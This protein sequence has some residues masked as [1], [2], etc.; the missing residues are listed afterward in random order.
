MQ[1]LADFSRVVPPPLNSGWKTTLLTSVFFLLTSIFLL[2]H[3]TT[4]MTFATFAD[5]DAD[6]S[7]VGF[8]PPLN[9][10]W[11]TTL[12][13]SIF[14]PLTSVFLLPHGTTLMT[15][16]DVDADVGRF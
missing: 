1:M 3:G 9:T 2:P 15:F 7:R 10:G 14:F 12:L 6:F 13:T 16:A 4:L 11:K 8:P 5:V